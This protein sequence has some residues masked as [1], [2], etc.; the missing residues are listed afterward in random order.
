MDELINQS[1]EQQQQNQPYAP[2][3]APK[4]DKADLLD[5]IRPDNIVEKV[6]R[7]LMGE[8]EID[9]S[10]VKVPFLKDRCLTDTGAWEIS[11]LMLPCSSQNVSISNLTDPEIKKRA[12][13]IAR[14]AQHMCIKNWK[15]YGIRGTDQLDY[16]H[17]IVFS[18]TFITLKHPLEAGV[19]RFIQ[20]T[21]T[22]V[23]MRSSNTEQQKSSWLSN[24]F[25]ARQ[26]R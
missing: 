21:T 11:T 15:E 6:R 9:G 22:E 4:E 17:E 13:G 12:L 5:K 14:T 24:A 26:M 10:W 8:A 18:N 23:S 3:F 1:Q 16:V 20:G 2:F 25:K 7:C 19:R